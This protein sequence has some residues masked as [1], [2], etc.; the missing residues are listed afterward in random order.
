MAS[1]EAIFQAIR[2]A[3]GD[4]APRL[5]YADWLEEHG[6]PDRAEFIR[7]QCELARLP[8]WERRWQEL[9]W[10]EPD[11]L[12][13]HGSRWR[14]ELP[15]IDGVTWTEFERGF[16]STVHIPN[17]EKVYR[18]AA[19]GAIARA[20]PVYRLEAPRLYARGGRSPGRGIGWLRTLRF[21]RSGW[22][23][24]GAPPYDAVASLW[25]LFGTATEFELLGV[26]PGAN[27]DWLFARPGKPLVTRLVVEGDHTVGLSLVRQLVRADWAS[28]LIQLK[29]GTTF[30]VRDDPRHVN[31]EGAR[32]LAR[33]PQLCRLRVLNLDGQC[34]R[35]GGFEALVTSPY[36]ADLRELHVPR[37]QIADLRA[38]AEPSGAPLTRLDLSG[39]EIG[40]GGA[41]L[42]PR[43]PRLAELRCLD[44]SDCAIG[45]PGLRELAA[46]PCWHTLR[47]LDLSSNR[48][49]T[50]GA[51][52]LKAAD[53]PSR[54]H[55]LRLANCGFADDA[56]RIL[57]TIPW[58][59][60]L[61]LVDLTYNNLGPDRLAALSQ[62]GGPKLV[63]G[64]LSSLPLGLRH[65]AGPVWR[66][67]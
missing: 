36:L 12:A 63:A 23:Q 37:C 3:P 65:T 22:L 33:S 62:R 31:V 39:N 18:E 5:I 42:V 50:A 56:G 7:V 55:R 59:D 38:F 25:E 60:E 1:D 24:R 49:G 40:D 27:L 52:A 44:L 57:E 43:S 2:D 64:G 53:P 47:Q 17:L 16:V 10:R 32:L 48:L 51:R 58:L 15:T 67:R 35:D 20:A 61:L 4:D 54:L 14:A 8:C 29:L 30:D 34:L 13:K 41:S 19:D 66:P 26:D 21:G 45:L 28:R 11:L 6:N 46:S 9:A